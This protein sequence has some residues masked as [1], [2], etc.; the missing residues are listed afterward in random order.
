M[1]Q[2][3]KPVKNPRYLTRKTN[4]KTWLYRRAVPSR[5]KQLDKRYPVILKTTGETDRE[6]AKLKRNLF[7]ESDNVMW[8]AL[9]DGATAEE[10]RARYDAS[11]ALNKAAG[12]DKPPEEMTIRDILKRNSVAFNIIGKPKETERKS[13]EI[14]SSDS[15]GNVTWHEEEVDVPIFNNT[16]HDAL[17]GKH[18]QPKQNV[19]EAY[20]ACLV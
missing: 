6:R 9:D 16:V 8:Q 18:K 3:Q 1:N 17:L 4:R 12:L 20:V 2:S 5:F 15:E 11:I 10:A 19:W 13:V 7:E 14:P